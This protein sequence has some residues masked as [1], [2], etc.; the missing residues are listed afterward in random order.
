MDCS[1]Y[2][3]GDQNFVRE[4]LI[5]LSFT[6]SYHYDCIENN[7]YF[8]NLIFRYTGKNIYKHMLLSE[9]DGFSGKVSFRCDHETTCSQNG[10]QVDDGGKL[11]EGDRAR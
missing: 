9:F 6:I 7:M 1:I 3:R 5:L 8:F 2:G 11:F 10:G 4:I